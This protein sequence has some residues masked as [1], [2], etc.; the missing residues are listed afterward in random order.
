MSWW[1]QVREPGPPPRVVTLPGRTEV[2]RDCDGI[3]LDD[4]T[5]SRRHVALE[6]VDGGVLITDLG[7]ANGTM[8]GEARLDGP[9]VLTAG[10]VVRLGETELIVVEGRETGADGAPASAEAPLDPADRP[11]EALRR[12]NKSRR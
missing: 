3:V 1:L 6:P 8:V 5:V 9:E 12:L 4:P 7:S 2:G 11:S 10:A